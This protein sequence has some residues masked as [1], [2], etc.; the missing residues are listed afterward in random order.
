MTSSNQRQLLND[1]P[2]NTP[3]LWQQVLEREDYPTITNQR[4]TSISI[5]PRHYT[6]RLTR[7]AGEKHIDAE[8]IDSVKNIARRVH[9]YSY[10]PKPLWPL[11]SSFQLLGDGNG[12][13]IYVVLTNISSQKIRK[14]LLNGTLGVLKNNWTS[15]WTWIETT[16]EKYPHP[17]IN[18][19]TIT[20]TEVIEAI[21]QFRQQL[22]NRMEQHVQIG[23]K[24]NRVY[25]IMGHLAEDRQERALPPKS[26]NEE[27]R[28]S[29]AAPAK[30]SGSK[31][32][33]TI[34]ARRKRKQKQTEMELLEGDEEILLATTEP[35]TGRASSTKKIRT[36][37]GESTEK[38]DNPILNTSTTEHTGT[39]SSEHQRTTT[40]S[41]KEDISLSTCVG[42]FNY[43]GTKIGP[44]L[45]DFDEAINELSVHRPKEDGN[46]EECI[47]YIEQRRDERTIRIGT[48]KRKNVVE[49]ITNLIEEN[50]IW[51]YVE[52]ELKINY[53][54]KEELLKEFGLQT[55]TSSVPS[56][57]WLPIQTS[58]NRRT[59]D[60]LCETAWGI[61]YNEEKITIEVFAVLR[62]RLLQQGQTSYF[63]FDFETSQNLF[64]STGDRN[65]NNYAYSIPAEG[66][67]QKFD[68]T[69]FDALTERSDGIRPCEQLGDNVDADERKHRDSDILTGGRDRR[70]SPNE[71][72]DN[73]SR[74]VS[75]KDVARTEDNGRDRRN[76]MDKKCTVPPVWPKR[77]LVADVVADK[78]AHRRH[79]KQ[80]QAHRRYCDLTQG[81]IVKAGASGK[82]S[83]L[84]A[85]QRHIQRQ[86]LSVP[87]TSELHESAQDPASLGSIDCSRA[88]SRIVIAAPTNEELQEQVMQLQA[89]LQQMQ[90]KCVAVS[91]SDS[92]PSDLE[93]RIDGLA[94]NI[95]T[96]AAE[97]KRYSRSQTRDKA[98]KNLTVLQTSWNLLLRAFQQTTLYNT[99]IPSL[100]NIGEQQG[101]NDSP[102]HYDYSQS[103]YKCFEPFDG[104]IRR[105]NFTN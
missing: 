26:K 38:E 75:D 18:I 15:A 78:E 32:W 92:K 19:K 2:S 77:K 6:I 9:N 71:V 47:Q 31:A 23:W 60:K 13:T 40:S 20:T 89:M 93:A 30:P 7:L 79:R 46:Y 34:V 69:R 44:E 42:T 52:W 59:F 76:E 37:K 12:K 39:S 99:V 3:G 4:E 8:Q 56:D 55:D 104:P 66:A 17:P 28:V 41:D 21:T 101:C 74:D 81:P 14:D 98:N 33:A 100:F 102:C 72:T 29:R 11:D 103:L 16:S 36:E 86:A 64:V 90:G 105:K 68:A 65:V 96:L 67:R 1:T 48:E 51:T 54:T 10:A 88:S 95:A 62:Q 63:T 43:S 94:A 27:A 22:E 58:Q 5:A 84:E 57:W 61:D 87:P 80:Q 83:P 97:V 85:L 45:K 24:K 53:D 50:E 73:E 49:A 70:L 82:F 35:I 91:S 25:I